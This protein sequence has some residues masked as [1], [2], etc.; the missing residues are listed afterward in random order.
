[1]AKK[2]GLRLRPTKLFT[3]AALQPLYSERVPSG[4]RWCLQSIAWEIDKVTSG[5]NTRVRLYVEGRGNKHFLDEQLTPAATWLY[6]RD[7]ND[8]LYPGER[9]ALEIDQ[10]QASTTAIMNISGYRE[11]FEE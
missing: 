7:E 8:F 2:D 3:S 10:A 5:G 1:M 4:I 11:A 6:T 9:L